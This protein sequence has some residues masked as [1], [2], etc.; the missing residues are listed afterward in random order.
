MAK[1][2]GS[3]GQKIDSFIKNI[4]RLLARKAKIY[5]FSTVFDQRRPYWSLLNFKRFLSQMF[6]E[7]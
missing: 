6:K 2:F 4:K 5:D 1:I 7:K 3:T